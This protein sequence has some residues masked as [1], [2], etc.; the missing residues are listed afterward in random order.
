MFRAA[1]LAIAI[2]LALA[3]AVPLSACGKR[4]NVEPP[5]GKPSTYPRSYPTQ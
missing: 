4:G 2:T 1:R 5:E 3:V